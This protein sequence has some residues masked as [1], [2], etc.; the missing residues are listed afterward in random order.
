MGVVFTSSAVRVADLP[1]ESLHFQVG[2]KNDSKSSSELFRIIA[3][4]WAS[5]FTQHQKANV[6]Q[7]LEC[8]PVFS[9]DTKLLSIIWTGHCNRLRPCEQRQSR[10]DQLLL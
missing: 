5:W 4:C 1:A 10:N 3:T 7:N 2:V 8:E 6:L 9:P